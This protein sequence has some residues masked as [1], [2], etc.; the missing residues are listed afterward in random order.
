M[1][2]E[3]LP[4]TDRPSPLFFMNN[5]V[6][7][8]S[9][10]TE[11][12]VCEAMEGVVNPSSIIGSQ[13][14][15]NVWRLYVNKEEAKTK[16][17]Q[18]GI[19][20]FGQHVQL[21]LQNPAKVNQVNRYIQP[22][23][24]LI[25]DVPMSYT[26]E[27]VEKMLCDLGANLTSSVKTSLVR[28]R[29]GMLTKYTNGD[30]FVY[31]DTTHTMTS[32]LPRFVLIGTFVAK[33][34]HNGQDI[35]KQKCNNCMSIEHPSW[36]CSEETIC[37]VCKKTDHITGSVE[38]EFYITNNGA[39]TFG[40]RNDPLGLSN[41]AECGFSFNGQYYPNREVAFQ[42]QRA[43]NCNQTELAEQILQAETPSEA[44]YLSRCLIKLG[45]WNSDSSTLMTKICLAA[46]N[47]NV[48][49]RANILKT[50]DRYL[51]ESIPGNYYWSTGLSHK[52]SKNTVTYMF[53]GDNEMGK[54]LMVVR[55][56]LISQDE[57]MNQINEEKPVDQVIHEQTAASPELRINKPAITP[58]P[59]IVIKRKPSE[60]PANDRDDKKIANFPT[61][62]Y[63]QRELNN[64]VFD[65]SNL[66]STQSDPLQ[67]SHLLSGDDD[68][69][70]TY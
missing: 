67:T 5:M 46:A 68:E 10:I 8:S 39:Y 30:R 64:T 16:L 11:Y 51:A 52:V 34:I 26:N 9:I 33:I 41:F 23:K 36:K 63:Q 24:I 14:I 48:T 58:K 22:T 4:N 27:E 20:V 70:Q 7:T 43:I 62:T 54:I 66:S 6:E 32:P 55:D 53:P 31:S 1:A 50:K 61:P 28:D 65:E 35:E 56:Q 44:K 69:N 29:N 2:Q 25:K 15:Q 45:L 19:G 40:G 21:Y 57:K 42:H 3:T 47:E 17:V 12:D 60:S 18:K 59:N 49:Y 38:C 13:K 37:K